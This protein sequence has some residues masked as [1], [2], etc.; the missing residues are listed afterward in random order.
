[1]RERRGEEGERRGMRGGDLLGSEGGRGGSPA[2]VQP[3]R[4]VAP[5]ER[6]LGQELL[7]EGANW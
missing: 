4:E 2:G 5:R 3:Q 1:M 7:Q 6:R